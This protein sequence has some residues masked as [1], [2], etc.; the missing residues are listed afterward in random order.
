VSAI[1]L[2]P[3]AGGHVLSGALRSPVSY[4]EMCRQI[5]CSNCKAPLE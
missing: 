4:S 3:G 1:V 5:P 2:S